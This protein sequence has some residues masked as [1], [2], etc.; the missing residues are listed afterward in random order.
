MLLLLQM[1]QIS[2]SPLSIATLGFASYYAME[3]LVWLRKDAIRRTITSVK[4]VRFNYRVKEFQLF[5]TIKTIRF[6]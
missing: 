3:N 5:Y 4:K 2:V 6:W 1:F